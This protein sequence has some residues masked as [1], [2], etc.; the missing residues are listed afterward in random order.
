M[1]SMDAGSYVASY[2]G[3]KEAEREEPGFYCMSTLSDFV[4]ESLD[5]N[6]EFLSIA[7]LFQQLDEKIASRIKDMDVSELNVNVQIAR[8]LF[9]RGS[10]VKAEAVVRVARR[11]SLRGSFETERPN[12]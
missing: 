4:S 10:S 12:S 7:E 11:D 8:H 5:A 6:W 9:E 3:K 2:F 1:D